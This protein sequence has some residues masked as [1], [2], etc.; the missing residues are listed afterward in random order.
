MRRGERGDRAASD[1]ATS[2]VDLLGDSFALNLF[3]NQRNDIGVGQ[4][5]DITRVF[6]V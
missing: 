3:P 6:L 4:S 1:P 2:S 5:R